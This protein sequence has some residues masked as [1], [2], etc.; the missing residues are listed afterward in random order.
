MAKLIQT[1]I[2]TI[3]PEW[4]LVG[5]GSVAEQPQ[6]GL[7]AKAGEVGNAKFLRITDIKEWGVDWNNVPHCECPEKN[8]AKYLLQ[9]GDIVFARIG[10]TTGKSYIITDPPHAVFASYL[11]RVRTRPDIDPKFLIYF[12]RSA[13][14]WAQINA[15]KNANLKK[16][17]SGSVLKSLLLPKPPLPEQKKIAHILST[18]QRAIEEQERII[19]AT[20]ELKK[21]LMHKLSTEGLHGEP[22]KETEIGLVPEGW[23]VTRFDSFCILQR[24]F[25]ITKKEQSLGEVP[26]VSSGGIASYHNASKV[27]GPGVVIGRK[28][29]LGTVHYINCDFWPHDTTLWV[30]DFKGNDPLFTAYFLESL[31]L[32]RFDSGAA[33]P[34]LNRNIVHQQIVGYPGVDDQR[35]IADL[36]GKIDGKSD[37]HKQKASL[38]KDLF[39]SLLHQLMTAQIRVHDIDFDDLDVSEAA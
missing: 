24:G 30:K 22:Q 3:A 4:D 19:Q 34:T 14:Y 5:L 10:A 31:Q 20:T 7:T 35:E 33:N 1:E 37:I 36:L 39:R 32:E 16:G 26:V 12:F 11:I 23:E 8:L 38:L 28:G 2:G 27:L 25:D 15:N 13:G 17:V 6:Y 9:P 18:V 29:S 21:A